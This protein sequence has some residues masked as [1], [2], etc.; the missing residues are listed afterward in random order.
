MS[1]CSSL[2]PTSPGYPH[3][4]LAK[5]IADGRLHSTIHSNKLASHVTL[6]AVYAFAHRITHRAESAAHAYYLSSIYRVCLLY[7]LCFVIACSM[8]R[9]AVT[10]LYPIILLG[11]RFTRCCIFRISVPLTACPAI[12]CFP[13]ACWNTG[14]Y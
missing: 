8:P 2:P 10:L 3:F 13:S 11:W 14:T 5:A 7:I 12:N 1:S 4:P 9:L 6:L